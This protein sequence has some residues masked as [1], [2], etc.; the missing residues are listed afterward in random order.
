MQRY[1]GAASQLEACLLAKCS[2]HLDI[3]VSV[4]GYIQRGGSPSAFDRVVGTRF[5]NRAVELIKV[6]FVLFS[7]SFLLNYYET[8]LV[9]YNPFIFHKQEEKFGHLVVIKGTEV[10]EVPMKE[11]TQGQ[12]FVS[13]DCEMVR[14]AR[15]CGV[16][17]GCGA[18]LER[19]RHTPDQR[20]EL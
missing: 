5:G 3:R 4:L 11:V 7:F 1:G 8:F 18:C 17:F 14:A 16:C 13:P 15:N 2:T 9:S 12:K 10:T 20:K 19:V 6:P